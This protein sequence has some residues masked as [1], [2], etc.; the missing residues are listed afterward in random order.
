M[1]VE[2]EIRELLT[3]Q[4]FDKAN[5][6]VIRG[7]GLKASVATDINDPWA[8]KVVE[9]MNA[10]DTYSQFQ[11]VILTKPFLMPVEDIFTIEGRGTVVTGRIERGI[12]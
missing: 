10:L 6:P 9:L 2:E 8:Q 4:G 5:T 7:S 1:L 11:S 3:K 12:R